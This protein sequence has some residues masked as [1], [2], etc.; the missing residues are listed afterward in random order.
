MH[1]DNTENVVENVTRKIADFIK[2]RM[3]DMIE[4]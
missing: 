1:V 4:G 2:L 3:M